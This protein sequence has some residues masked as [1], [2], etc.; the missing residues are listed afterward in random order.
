MG[1]VREIAVRA[2]NGIVGAAT[3][4]PLIP[5]GA[6]GVITG[7]L[8]SGASW[9]GA[10]GTLGWLTVGFAFFAASYL[11]FAFGSAAL[12]RSKLWRIEVRERGRL[13]GESPSFDPMSTVYRDKQLYLRDLAPM[14]RKQVIGKRFINCELIGPGTAVLGMKSDIHGPDYLMRKVRTFDVDCIQIVAEPRSQLAIE[15]VDCDFDECKFYHMTLLFFERSND[16]LHWITPDLRPPALLPAP[17]EEDDNAEYRE[18]FRQAS[19]GHDP[20]PKT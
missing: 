15:F 4:W 9:I 14:G 5:A 20:R 13:A 18:A 11:T 7:W 17:L 6:I 19:D 16:T 2:W 1:K 10:F 8:A 12:S 3:L